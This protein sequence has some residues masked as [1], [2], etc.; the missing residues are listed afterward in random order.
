VTIQTDLYA[1]PAGTGFQ[2]VAKIGSI[3][4]GTGSALRAYGM[5]LKIVQQSGPEAGR[6]LPLPAMTKL[7]AQITASMKV[8]LFGV[9]GA[10]PLGMQALFDPV[11]AAVNMALSQGNFTNALEIITTAPVA[12][13]GVSA[14]VVTTL[15]DIINFYQ[16]LLSIF[17]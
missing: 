17:S 4:P 2:V 7:I 1:G 12:T 14:G 9:F 15:T 5:L 11:R 16:S 13:L 3:T 8:D 6:N 10:Q